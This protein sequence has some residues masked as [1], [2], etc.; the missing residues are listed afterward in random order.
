MQRYTSN[1]R[2]LLD[3][4]RCHQPITR[5]DVT[6]LTDLT[7]QSVHRILEG[8]IADGLVV[9][10]RGKPNGRGKPSPTI[11][12][13]ENARY[14]IGISIDPDGFRLSIVNFSGMLVAD[15][16]VSVTVE[17]ETTWA[18]SLID[19]CERTLAEHEI[20]QHHL[21]GIGIAI[22]QELRPP[23][24][25]SHQPGWLTDLGDA[26]NVPTFLE[27]RAVAA[28]IG[29][30]LTGVGRQFKNFAF[31]SMDHEVSGGLIYDGMPFRGHS[32]NAGYFSYLFEEEG[33]PHPI[34]VEALLKELERSG[35]GLVDLADLQESFDVN[36]PGVSI[37]LD[38]AVACIAKLVRAIT[39][40]VDPQ[41]IIFGG[42]MPA[43]IRQVLIEELGQ[44]ELVQTSA[45]RSYA[46]LLLLSEIAGDN[47]ATGS[48]L[49][50]LKH[51]YFR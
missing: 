39:G 48:A 41:A 38:S 8:L 36:W 46:P 6:G 19:A 35:S 37:W 17:R 47:A 2:M 20:D 24:F 21:C 29:E 5:A 32:G 11:Q 43:A 16:K 4:L 31:I 9:T 34:S 45:D 49:L 25:Q 23:G 15:R 13:D 22:S 44:R 42:Q 18:A 7:Q 51:L 50:P 27:N 28:A 14:S 10:E 30:S 26:L 1:Q 40:I 12:L 33:E 3:I